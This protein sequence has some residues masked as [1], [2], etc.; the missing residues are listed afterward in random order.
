MNPTSSREIDEKIG[1]YQVR[2]RVNFGEKFVLQPNQLV[3]GSTLEYISLPTDMTSQVI[4]RS[5]WAG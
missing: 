3:L 5:S 1:Q 2:V 4:G